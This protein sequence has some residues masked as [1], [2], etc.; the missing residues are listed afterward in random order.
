MKD[1]TPI[2][3]IK[4]YACHPLLGTGRRVIG[5]L[6]F[7][8][9]SR[10]TF[11]PEDLS[12][13]KA[14][15]MIR[16]QGEQALRVSGEALQRANEQLEERI[17]GRTAELVTLSRE[18]MESR[19][20]LRSLATELAVTEARE[21]RALASELHDTVAQTLA[22]AK[23]R[24]ESIGAGLEATA[25]KEV[26]KVVKL[27]QQANRETRSL[28]SE[29][30]LSFLYEAGLEAALRALAQRMEEAHSLAIEVVDD[31]SP[32]PLG[33]DSGIVLYR[34]VR[35]LL[36]NAVK[37]AKATRV[38]VSLQRENRAVRIEVKDDGLGFLPSEVRFDSR[39]GELFGL[40]SIHERM[41]HLGGSFEV[42]SRPG[43][44]VRAVLVIPLRVEESEKRALS[45][46]RI[47]IADDHKLMRD[48]L[49]GLLEKEPGFE[50]V[51]EAANGLEAVHLSKEVKPDIVIMDISMPVM[52]G[53]EAT[54]QITAELSAVKVI[55]LSVQTEPQIASNIVAAGACS[56][57][58]K[59]ASPEELTEVIRT[60][61]GSRK[62]N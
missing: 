60:A 50:I 36:T 19:D 51:G 41:Q 22:I 17:R 38:E 39:K 5:T 3:G 44:G 58:P 9:R 46:V 6:S 57:V 33:E 34:A 28:M 20:R 29:L 43:E 35:E 25:T 7:G 4:A 40:F 32:K 31:G 53:I 55:G 26:K 49:R 61:V 1:L 12:L 52:D 8:T 59:G 47:L 11:S 56:F 18:L 42:V 54:R 48:G 10:E 2:H 14:V 15:A 45:R 27:L 21:R 62:E 16:M 13:M 30:S 23:L 24:L 37:H